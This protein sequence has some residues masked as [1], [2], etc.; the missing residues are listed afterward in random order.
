MKLN[1]SISTNG[2]QRQWVLGQDVPRMVPIRRWFYHI[3]VSAGN[4][5]RKIGY[6]V[7]Y[8]VGRWT[9]ECTVI[10]WPPKGGDVQSAG[11]NNVGRKAAPV[12]KFSTEAM[13]NQAKGEK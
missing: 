13:L 5:G 1:L 4:G 3:R 11:T 9:D 10:W 8:R 6:C 2:V 7:G 12:L